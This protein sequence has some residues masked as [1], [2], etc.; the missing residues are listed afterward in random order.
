MKLINEDSIKIATAVSI[1]I[2]ILSGYTWI[3]KT[4]ATKDSVV[5]MALDI[6]IIR[7]NLLMLCVKNGI[8]WQEVK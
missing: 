7:H 6:K 3:N 1:L 5:Q 8:K 2:L 4:F